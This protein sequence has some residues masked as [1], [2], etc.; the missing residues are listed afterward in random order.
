MDFF[1][2]VLIVTSWLI[3]EHGRRIYIRNNLTSQD[4]AGVEPAPPDPED[5]TQKPQG[6]G[7]SET[8]LM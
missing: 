7:M 8:F 1:G 4:I 5:K 6:R 3:N 2:R